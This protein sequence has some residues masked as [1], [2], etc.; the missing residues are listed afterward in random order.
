MHFLNCPF[1]WISAYEQACCIAGERCHRRA[2]FTTFF[3]TLCRPCKL[4]SKGKIY[5]LLFK[6]DR[7]GL[8]LSSP[9]CATLDPRR[10]HSLLKVI[11]LER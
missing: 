3:C 4:C 8:T 10:N 7:L 9:M 11:T 5:F 1:L 2:F 6:I